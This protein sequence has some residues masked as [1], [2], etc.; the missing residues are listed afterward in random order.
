MIVVA[1]API[2]SIAHSKMTTGTPTNSAKSI[3]AVSLC[4]TGRTP[5]GCF[6]RVDIPLFLAMPS[7]RLERADPWP[8]PEQG[9][10]SR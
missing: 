2:W 7:L 6:F 1:A 5:H 8:S 9:Q 3:P 4:V 10:R